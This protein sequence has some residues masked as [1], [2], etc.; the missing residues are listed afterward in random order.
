MSIINIF[1]IEVLSFLTSFSSLF[2]FYGPQL[3]QWELG[4][5]F[6]LCH[7]GHLV[8]GAAGVWGT[9]AVAANQSVLI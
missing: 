4:E 2:W 7:S 3:Y 6:Q 9:G 5:G 1:I 8:G